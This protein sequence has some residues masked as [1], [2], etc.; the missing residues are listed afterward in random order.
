[1]LHAG[2]PG[3]GALAEA[4]EDYRKRL[5]RHPQVKAAEVFV[6][7]VKLRRESPAEVARALATEGERLLAKL[8]PSD[9]VVALDRSGKPRSSPELAKLLERWEIQGHRGVTFLLGSSHGLAEA[10]VTRA[11]E[12]LSFGPLTLPHDLARVVF[13]EQLF[14]ARAI[15]DGTPY[16]K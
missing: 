4:A 2:G 7:P 6:K 10:V 15:R 12:R 8:E 1:M 5:D 14:R 13:W 3:R 9:F 16:H 11:Q